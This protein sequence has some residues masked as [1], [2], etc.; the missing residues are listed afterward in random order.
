ML[1]GVD[2]WVK[3]NH[4]L[5]P[6][7]DFDLVVFVTPR[8]PTAFISGISCL[9]CMAH[10]KQKKTAIYSSQTVCTLIKWSSFYS[11]AL[12][13]NYA[14]FSIFFLLACEKIACFNWVLAVYELVSLA[15][16]FVWVFLREHCR[17]L[18]SAAT[19]AATAAVAVSTAVVYTVNSF[20]NTRSA[21]L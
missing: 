20:V 19:A 6:L 15:P 16:V 7:H 17:S 2:V 11:G 4:S 10:N 3:L 1:K 18:L 5:N 8:S 9:V 12:W 14:Q 13:S 21:L